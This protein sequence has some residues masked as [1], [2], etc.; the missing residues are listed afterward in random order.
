MAPLKEWQHWAAVEADVPGSGGPVA[1]NI[2]DAQRHQD[3][4]TRARASLD[5]ELAAR[6]PAECYDLLGRAVATAATDFL[7]SGTERTFFT[8]TPETAIQLSRSRKPYFCLLGF[9]SSVHLQ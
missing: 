5:P 6:S 2:S 1:T 7:L 9:L 4:L 3:R 8:F